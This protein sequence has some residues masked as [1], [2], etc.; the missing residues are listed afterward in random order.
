V[1]GGGQ[2]LDERRGEVVE[3]V[4]HRVDRSAGTVKKS[5][6]PPSFHPQ[7]KNS[8]FSQRLARPLVHILQCPQGGVGSTVTGNHVDDVGSDGFDDTDHLMSRVVREGDEWMRAVHGMCVGATDTGDARADQCV[9]WSGF[10]EFDPFHAHPVEIGDD[11][12]HRR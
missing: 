5:A 12:T 8:R 4:R 10:G 3:I 6:V 9:T 2:R 7:P 1:H 11:S